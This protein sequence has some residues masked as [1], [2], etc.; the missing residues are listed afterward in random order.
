MFYVFIFFIFLASYFQFFSSC[1]RWFHLKSRTSPRCFLLLIE[2]SPSSFAWEAIHLF[3]SMFFFYCHLC[4]VSISLYVLFLFATPRC[5]A[6]LWFPDSLFART[7]FPTDSWSA[8]PLKISHDVTYHTVTNSLR[9]LLALL[10]LLE[11]LVSIKWKWQQI[12]LVTIFLLPNVNEQWQRLTVLTILSLSLSLFFCQFSMSYPPVLMFGWVAIQVKSQSTLHISSPTYLLFFSP[13]VAG[14]SF[15]L[16]DAGEL[17]VS[18]MM[19]SSSHSRFVLTCVFCRRLVTLRPRRCWHVVLFPCRAFVVS[20][21]GC[22]RSFFSALR[23]N[24]AL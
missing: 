16:F 4:F 24:F 21:T 10:F 6:I 23:P 3:Q 9:S 11:D 22:V 2:K 18:K 20:P 8:I 15:P 14:E 7:L 5:F 19:A 17:S 13:V 1:P 12:V